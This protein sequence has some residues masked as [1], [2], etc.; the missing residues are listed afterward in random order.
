VTDTQCL[1][2]GMYEVYKAGHQVALD[3]AAAG[4]GNQEELKQALGLNACASHY[5]SDVLIRTC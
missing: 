2:I 5:L 3:R 4:S 1:K